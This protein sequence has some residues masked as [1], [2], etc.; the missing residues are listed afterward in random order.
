M[1]PSS[2]PGT[3]ETEAGRSL[4]PDQPQLDLLAG[5]YNEEHPCLVMGTV[6]RELSLANR[7]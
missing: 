2:N 4:V 1:V 7:I 6:K 3:E 5:A